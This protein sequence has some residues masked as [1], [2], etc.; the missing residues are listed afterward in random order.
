MELVN[1]EIEL[2]ELFSITAHMF[3]SYTRLYW[4]PLKTFD[5]FFG[6]FML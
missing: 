2:W 5:G 4:V 3:Y 6:L 1:F